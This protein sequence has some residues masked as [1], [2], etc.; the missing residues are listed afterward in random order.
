MTKLVKKRWRLASFINC[1]RMINEILFSF[2]MTIQC[3]LHCPRFLFHLSYLSSLQGIVSYEQI[4]AQFK[5]HEEVMKYSDGCWLLQNWLI[6]DYLDSAWKSSAC[7]IA[8]GF[9]FIWVNNE[10]RSRHHLM[11]VATN[12]NY[13]QKSYHQNELTNNNKKLI[14]YD[15]SQCYQFFGWVAN[16]RSN[17]CGG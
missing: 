13:A 12:T 17:H 11:Q 3:L 7:C 16:A 14:S 5:T 1:Q 10:P 15:K 2:C 9:C 4:T 6:K 8:G